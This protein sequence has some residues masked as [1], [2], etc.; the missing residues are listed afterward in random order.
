VS[1]RL[2]AW[3]VT[4]T[5]GF[6]SAWVERD[7]LVLRAEGVSVGQLP[8][9][10]SLSYVLETDAHAATTLLR[11][12]LRTTSAERKLELRRAE[13][14]WTVNS[15]PRMDLGGALDCDLACSPL[16]NTMPII[17]HRLHVEAGDESFTMAFVRLPS[18]AVL[19]VP[20]RY[21][22]LAIGS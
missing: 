6:E 3:H 20:Q 9:P 12:M 21:Q 22:H 8:G 19:A 14:G 5:A 18:L 10:C 17:R 4:E 2:L 7:G 15:E 1:G 13:N 11:V 16:T